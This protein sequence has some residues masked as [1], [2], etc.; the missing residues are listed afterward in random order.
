MG[1][2]EIEDFKAKIVIYDGSYKK[3]ISQFNTGKSYPEKGLGDYIKGEAVDDLLSGD[4]VS[5]LVLAMDEDDKVTDLIAYFT[6][7]S[8]ALPYIYRTE[9]DD[10]DYEEMC[11]IP[12]IRISAF[13]VS[14]IYQ[15]VF[16]K[17]QPIAAHVFRTIISIVDRMSSGVSG[18]KAIY[19]HTL[20]SAKAFYLKNKMLEMEEYMKPFAGQDEDLDLMYVFIR[21]VKLVHERKRKKLKWYTRIKRRIAKKLLE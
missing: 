8:S 5:Y 13:G 11:G 15:D 2:R 21:E 9:D 19:L 18:I 16:Y 10:G 4:G 20:P 14:D 12:A 17:G 6:L 1:H 7:V 3:I